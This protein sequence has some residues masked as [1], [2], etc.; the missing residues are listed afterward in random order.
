[1]LFP[2]AMCR[3]PTTERAEF[4]MMKLTLDRIFCP[5]ALGRRLKSL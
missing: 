1:M 4:T 2:I 3:T 5:A